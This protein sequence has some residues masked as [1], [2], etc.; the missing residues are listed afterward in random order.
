MA[1]NTS[2]N[3]S[4]AMSMFDL[5]LT[6]TSSISTVFVSGKLDLV[7]DLRN[8]SQLER[9]IAIL[10]NFKLSSSVK[11]Q[12]Q[13][14]NTKSKIIKTKEE[15]LESIME[16]HWRY[17]PMIVNIPSNSQVFGQ[18]VRSS[19][20][21]GILYHSQYTKRECLAIFPSNLQDSLSF[22]KLLNKPPNDKIP[23]KIDCFNYDIC[24]TAFSTLK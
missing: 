21:S 16:S 23:I 5:S 7:F 6:R 4:S 13:S 17:K 18:M 12:G 15:L 3:I 24:E 14:L 1:S 9:V 11:R 19:G 8:Y 10:K 22:I 20:I 2:S